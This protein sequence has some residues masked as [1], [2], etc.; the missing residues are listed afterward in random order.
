[1]RDFRVVVVADAVASYDDEVH[2]ASLRNIERHF[3]SVVDAATLLERW[4]RGRG[5]H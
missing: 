1:M 3:G 2:E 5:R 4:A